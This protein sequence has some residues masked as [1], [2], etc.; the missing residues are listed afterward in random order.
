MRNPK[1]FYRKPKI[2]REKSTSRIG[3]RKQKRARFLSGML[4]IRIYETRFMDIVMWML[5][6]EMESNLL[7]SMNIF[8]FTK[9]RKRSSRLFYVIG[10]L[11]VQ[12]VKIKCRKPRG[13]P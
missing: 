4:I 12:S 9:K 6:G 11:Y 3:R 8:A 10:I 5:D 13:S 7:N 2:R 1:D